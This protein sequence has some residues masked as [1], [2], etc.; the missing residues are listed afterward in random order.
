MPVPCSLHGHAGAWAIKTCNVQ[1][2]LQTISNLWIM[3]ERFQVKTYPRKQAGDILIIGRKAGSLYLFPRSVSEPDSQS[4][5]GSSEAMA[6][7][8]FPHRLMRMP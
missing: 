5:Q 7:Q 1:F 8:L 3:S 4:D 6:G 2:S